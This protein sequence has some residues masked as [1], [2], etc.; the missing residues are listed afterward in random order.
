MPYVYLISNYK[1][2]NIHS[3]HCTELAKV[4]DFYAQHNDMSLNYPVENYL[5]RMV[6][7]EELTSDSAAIERVT[8]FTKLPLAEKIKLI[9]SINP[10]WIELKPGVNI[11][12]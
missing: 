4:I 10:D 12:L 5:M 7:L 9:E 6:Y 11:E 8:H 3:G 1:H 2:D